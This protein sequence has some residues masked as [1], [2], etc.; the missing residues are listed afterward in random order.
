MTVTLHRSCG[1]IGLAL[2]TFYAIATPTM[3]LL[4]FF[5]VSAVYTNSRLAI[6]FFGLCWL[7]VAAC[8]IYDA[9]MAFS[10]FGHALDSNR[11]VLILRGRVRTGGTSLTAI[12]FC[13]TAVFLAISWRLLPDPKTENC[14]KSRITSFF[15]G[16]GMLRLS[17]A[18]LRNGQLYYA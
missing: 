13:D 3:A 4:F 1:A 8:Y 16:T 9:I 17:R 7:C 5:R 11:C 2:C 10:E 18:L 14:W 15:T 12:A 6:T